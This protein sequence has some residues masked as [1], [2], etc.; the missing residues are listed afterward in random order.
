M[1]KEQ[2]S[3]GE[4]D[5]RKVLEELSRNAKR[6]KCCRERKEAVEKRLE[7]MTEERL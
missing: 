5:A 7:N 1:K 4:D 2:P 6:V 3:I